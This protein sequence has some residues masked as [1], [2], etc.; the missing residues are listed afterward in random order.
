MRDARAWR[1]WQRHGGHDGLVVT[2]TAAAERDEEME[3]MKG[4]VRNLVRKEILITSVLESH[5]VDAMKPEH[6]ALTTQ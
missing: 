1:V 3:I 2:V 5:D 6:M 4:G